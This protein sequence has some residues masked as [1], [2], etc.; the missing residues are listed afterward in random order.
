[1]VSTGGKTMFSLIPRTSPAF[2]N[3]PFLP[4]P[5]GSDFGHFVDL[6]AEMDR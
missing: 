1:M 6:S 2:F 3:L 5:Y 4:L